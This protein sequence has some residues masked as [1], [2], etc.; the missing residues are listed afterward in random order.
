[1]ADGAVFQVTLGTKTY[2]ATLASTGVN[3]HGWLPS[4]IRK[5]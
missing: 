3:R 5:A 2:R 4:F 1:M